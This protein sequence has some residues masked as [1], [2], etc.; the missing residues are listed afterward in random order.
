MIN[1]LL[2]YFSVVFIN[3]A[4]GQEPI[5]LLAIKTVLLCTVF[6]VQLGPKLLNLF[7]RVVFFELGWGWPR[8]VLTASL[9]QAYH[10]TI[11]LI[12]LQIFPNHPKFIPKFSKIIPTLFLTYR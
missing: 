1:S 10:T 6:T 11:L 12:I 2:E 8:L 4:Q 9:Y 5:K 3:L 7:F